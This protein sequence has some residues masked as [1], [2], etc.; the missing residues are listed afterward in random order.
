M[1]RRAT[2]LFALALAMMGGAAGVLEYTCHHQRLGKPGVTIVP[3]PL[4]DEQGVLTATNSIYLPESVLGST[5][6]PQPLS[7]LELGWLPLDT[8]FGR[9]LYEWP[10]HSPIQISVVLMGADRTSIHKPEYCLKGQ[11]WTF[12]Q[13]D[14]GYLQLPMER[15]FPYE[16][17]IRIIPITST[18]GGGTDESQNNR[19]GF[20]LYWFV[21]DKEITAGHGQRMLSQS[22]HMLRTGEVQ[23]WAYITCFSQC[24]A[25]QEPATLEW[26]K[27]VI[28]AAVPEFQI[29]PAAPNQPQAFNTK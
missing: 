8:T 10:D 14:M 22:L 20:Y 17:P 2:I 4:Y 23:R 24:L 18:V 3:V 15:P 19:R 26:M 21:T 29:P 12:N 6:K 11:A 27:K 9:R 5:S 7:R 25:G 16:L 13:D 28:V 1:N